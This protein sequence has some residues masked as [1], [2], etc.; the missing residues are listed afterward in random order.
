MADGTAA[1]TTTAIHM[2][3][4]QLKSA[5]FIMISS[6]LFVTRDPEYGM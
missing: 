3:S 5:A 1:M 4:F 6:P 2:N